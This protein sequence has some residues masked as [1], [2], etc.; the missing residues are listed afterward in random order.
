MRGGIHGACVHAYNMHTGTPIFFS[1]LRRVAH[2]EEGSLPIVHY[3]RT[4]PAGGTASPTPHHLDPRVV[5]LREAPAAC[6]DAQLDV[7]NARPARFRRR[8]IR[9]HGGGVGWP[10]TSTRARDPPVQCSP[11]S[12][13]P[14]RVNVIARVAADA[15]FPVTLVGAAAL[16]PCVC[17]CARARLQLVLRDS[18]DVL[19]WCHM[20]APDGTCES[21]KH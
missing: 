11:P 20:G 5:A 4:R 9:A 21:S 6:F 19:R 7:A 14:P 3:R 8:Q 18:S 13:S 1:R 2:T 15:R 10:G 17:V 16:P 12:P